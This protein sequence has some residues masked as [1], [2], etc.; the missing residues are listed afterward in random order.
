[1]T[2]AA[3]LDGRVRDALVV[4]VGVGWVASII[5][6]IFNPNYEPDPSINAAFALVIGAALGIG[7]KESNSKNPRGAN[8][9][10]A[11]KGP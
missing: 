10:D 3:M 4:L 9:D 5:G 8:D 7:K 1:M 2:G 11:Q 6:S